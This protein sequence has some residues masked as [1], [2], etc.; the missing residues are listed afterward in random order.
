MSPAMARAA[1]SFNRSGA[2]KLGNPWARLRESC[3]R[4]RRVIPRMTDSRKPWVRRAVVNGRLS[5]FLLSAF[6]Q[7]GEMPA[8]WVAPECSVAG[9]QKGLE[10]VSFRLEGQH[11]LKGRLR[12]LGR[13]IERRNRHRSPQI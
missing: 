4:A 9:D 10:F 5:P 1:A 12:R 8:G 13:G 11:H 3:S 7:V 2:G 6:D